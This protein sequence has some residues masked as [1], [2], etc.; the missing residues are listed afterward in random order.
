MHIRTFMPAGSFAHQ[1]MLVFSSQVKKLHAWFPDKTPAISDASRQSRRLQAAWAVAKP[2]SHCRWMRTLGCPQDKRSGGLARPV[3]DFASMFDG[4]G[5]WF[6][7]CRGPMSRY[8]VGSD[9]TNHRA[10][11]QM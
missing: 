10:F 7:Y 1:D 9:S 8:N 4:Y 2:R 6:E 11:L 5:C 3:Q